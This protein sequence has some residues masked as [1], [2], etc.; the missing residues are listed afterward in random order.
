MPRSA[1]GFIGFEI[2]VTH[3]SAVDPDKGILVSSVGCTQP[4]VVTSCH[5]VHK[6]IFGC[7]LDGH[8]A[9]L[10]SQYAHRR[11]CISRLPP[12]R[13]RVNQFVELAGHMVVRQRRVGGQHGRHGDIVTK[14]SIVAVT[15]EDGIVTSQAVDCV[16]TRTTG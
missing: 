5:R 15:T 11:C 6:R 10:D 2:L 16:V 4:N 9:S 14:D 12:S 1:I 13:G 7:V 3:R 8:Q